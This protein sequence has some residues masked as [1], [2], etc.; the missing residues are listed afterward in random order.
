M[1]SRTESECVQ[2]D[3]FARREGN[4]P[5]EREPAP[6]PALKAFLESG[7]F[8]LP[9]QGRAL[10]PGCG[11]VRTCATR[12]TGGL[13]HQRGIIMQGHDAIAIASM[14]GLHTLGVDRA[15]TA[16]AA[17]QQCEALMLPESV[18]TRGVGT[19]LQ[20]ALAVGLQRAGRVCRAG[21]LWTIRRTG[22]A[23]CADL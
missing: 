20:A 8:E 10:V 23:I 14:L 6:Q 9:R 13:P 17:A 19:R 5:W 18:L 2:P 21:F 4:T 15:P 11:R 1:A 12:C 3:K 16:I 22:S 7:G